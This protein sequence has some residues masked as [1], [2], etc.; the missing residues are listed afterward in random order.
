MSDIPYQQKSEDSG[1][2]HLGGTAEELLPIV[3]EE[4]RK[5]ARHKMAKLPPGHTLQPTALVHEAFMR[6][7]NS[8]THHW[9]NS[10]HFFAVAAEAMRHLLIDR[11]RSKLSRKHGEGQPPIG[12]EQID[13][14]MESDDQTLLMVNESVDRLAAIDP[15]AAQFVK[16]RFFV[17]LRHREIADI[18]GL[19]ERSSKRLWTF[20]RTWLFKEIKKQP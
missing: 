11:A 1:D 17:G 18:M 2:A 16:L 9:E 7:A 15:D 20:A 8:P 12:L 5:L 10:R 4:L 13:V 14:A 19:S 6:L 3:Y